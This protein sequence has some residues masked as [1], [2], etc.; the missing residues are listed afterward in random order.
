MAKESFAEK[1]ARKAF[2]KPE[3]QQSWQV[4]M[5][6]FGPVLEHA[7]EQDYQ[8]RIHLIAALNHLS[9]REVSQAHQK[10]EQ[11]RKRLANDADHLAWTF[12]KGLCF[13]FGGDTEYMLLCYTTVTE[14]GLKFYMPYIKLA[15][16]YQKGHLYDRAEKQYLGAIACFDG[17]GL[18]PQEKLILGSAYAGAATC[19]TMMHQ[20]AEAEKLL[21]VSRQLWSDGPGRS[22]VEAVLY[23]AL[24]HREKVEAALEVLKNH[25]PQA[26][27]EIKQTAT[28]ILAGEEPMFAPVTVDREKLSEFWSWFAESETMLLDA[29][30]ECTDLI[31]S[32]LNET[33]PV[34]E[35]EL[36]VARDEQGTLYLQH[37]FSVALED[38]F[39]KLLACAPS[40]LT[41]NWHFEI[42][43]YYS[44]HNEK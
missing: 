23:A 15:K 32:K 36:E 33:F 9:R 22:A 19:R 31:S 38:G 7:F 11:L 24:N 43:P 16:F 39:R 14:H 27:E 12:F 17:T 21:S 35:G 28:K 1:M 8:A 20:Y 5:A 25:A 13:E 37:V 10:L 42:V 34:G 29:D 3:V 4:H 40:D 6:A 30:E 18:G 2:E 41:E 44:R 26:Y